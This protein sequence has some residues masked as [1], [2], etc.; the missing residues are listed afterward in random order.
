MKLS[1]KPSI[2]QINSAGVGGKHIAVF[3][4]PFSPF[5]FAAKSLKGGP[6]PVG[7]P[8][9]GKQR[10]VTSRSGSG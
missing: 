1:G 5:F 10:R 2:I 6:S 8:N 4:C 3:F 9:C 7:R